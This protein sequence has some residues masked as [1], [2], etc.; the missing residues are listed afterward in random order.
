MPLTVD[1][2]YE[3]FI[4]EEFDFAED[5]FAFFGKQTLGDLDQAAWAKEYGTYLPTW[6]PSQVNLAGRKRDLSYRN[7]MNLLETTQAATDSVYATELDTLST[8]LG[9]EMSKGREIAGGIGLR[10]GALESAIQDT[11]ATTGSTAKDFG[12]RM[13]I[14]GKETKDKYNSTMVDSAL[15]FEKTE[16]DEKEEFYDRTMATIMRLMETG[17]FDESIS[18][19]IDE[20]Y[21][22]ELGE[23]RPAADYEVNQQMYDV[24]P[25]ETID[26]HI[27]DVIDE[28]L[29]DAQCVG[30]YTISCNV[31]CGGGL[32]CN[33]D[34]CVRR[35]C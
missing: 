10:S 4:D 19:S 32:W 8:S 16:R 26:E 29:M 18:C 7:A 3:A 17:A 6:D 34:E 5:V 23:C 24:D 25:E 13:R 1:E 9:R 12:D 31:W 20:V 15:D 35:N 11:I 33:V 21:D 22:E 27:G 14:T 2:L 28:A 30:S